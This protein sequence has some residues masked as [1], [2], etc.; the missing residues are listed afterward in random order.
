MLA[1]KKREGEI[2]AGKTGKTGKAP[3]GTT[4]GD[5]LDKYAAEVSVKNK[6]EPLFSRWTS[7][8]CLDRRESVGFLRLPTMP[9][10]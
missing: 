8:R 6:G 2:M 5:L 7:H 10:H 9:R 1:I 3:A 4:F